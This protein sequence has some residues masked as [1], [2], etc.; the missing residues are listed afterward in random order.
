M[1]A[2]PV[3]NSRPH[4]PPASASQSAGI[5]GVSHCAWLPVSFIVNVKHKLLLW[6]KANKQVLHLPPTF[7][8]IQLYLTELQGVSGVLR[9]NPWCSQ[10]LDPILLSATYNFSW[11]LAAV[12][13]KD[14]R[15]D[16]LQPLP[17]FAHDP[18]TS[19][20]M[21]SYDRILLAHWDP[22]CQYL[23]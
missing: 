14:Q 19:S 22:G 12:L 21:P 15:F 7:S 3:S 8:F 18:I 2:R 1:L 10:N 11:S 16:I 5:T 17:C 9:N 23:K 13:G 6:V 20:N 4:D